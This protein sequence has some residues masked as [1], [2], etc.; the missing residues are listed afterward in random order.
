MDKMLRFY[1]LFITLRLVKSLL[2]VIIIRMS[3]WDGWMSIAR[4]DRIQLDTILIAIRVLSEIILRLHPRIA[5][6]AAES[7][8]ASYLSAVSNTTYTVVICSTAK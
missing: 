2:V 8:L 7:V 6:Y 4:F 3:G 1:E 5:S